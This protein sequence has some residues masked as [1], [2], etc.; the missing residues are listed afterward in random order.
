MEF[1]YR[2]SIARMLFGIG[3]FTL[4]FAPFYLTEFFYPNPVGINGLSFL[5]F[6]LFCVL[7]GIVF[8]RLALQIKT[9]TPVELCKSL[10]RFEFIAT[11]FLALGVV[12]ISSVFPLQ[13]R[14]WLYYTN[15]GLTSFQIVIRIVLFV[16]LY[17][18]IKKG[19][20]G[21]LPI[22]NHVHIGTSMLFIALNYYVFAIVKSYYVDVHLLFDHDIAGLSEYFLM[23]SVFEVAVGVIVLVQALFLAFETHLSGK[24]GTPVDL[25]LNFAHSRDIIVKNHVPSYISL[26]TVFVMFILAVGSSF[27]AP[28]AYLFLAILYGFVLL[29][30]IPS[31][32]IKWRVGRR[33]EPKTGF[34]YENRFVIVASFLLAAY[35]LACAFFGRAAFER[36]GGVERT[37][38][39]TFGIFVPW[40][41][42]KMVFA[43]RSLIL[44]RRKGA[45]IDLLNAFIDMLLSLFTLAQTLALISAKT[46][47]MVLHV[48]SIVLASII[49]IYCI[50]S[51][52]G[53]IAVG[54]AGVRGKRTKALAR[55]LFFHEEDPESGEERHEGTPEE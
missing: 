3:A 5:C 15:I 16:Y 51:S 4:C 31:F 53:M 13:A 36:M 54:V 39:M 17:R 32:L 33:Y 30:R 9:K 8:I 23:M 25:K 21:L 45:P 48:I 34:F 52:I 37:A 18:V 6:A 42:F 22:R 19:D 44:S 7:E 20:T 46:Q 47:A 26:F 27:A 49:G 14:D 12:S 41:V 38:F 28:E 50:L 40:S 10:S 1:A 29:I 35:G 24:T 55:Y 2:K 43:I 11:P